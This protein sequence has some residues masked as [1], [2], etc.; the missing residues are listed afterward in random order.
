MNRAKRRAETR[1]QQKEAQ[2]CFHPRGLARAVAHHMMEHQ[3]IGGINKVRPGATQSSFSIHWRN[4]ADRI[5]AI[6]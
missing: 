6:R 5:A 4:I 3:D 1:R 2:G